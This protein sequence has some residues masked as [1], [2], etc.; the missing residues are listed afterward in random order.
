MD[1]QHY[2]DLIALRS[3]EALEAGEQ[4]ELDEHLRLCAECRR[5]AHESLEAASLI[6]LSAEPIRPPEVVKARLMRE[7]GGRRDARGTTAS[8]WWLAAA[9]MLLAGLLLSQFALWK[10]RRDL[11]S[12]A[13]RVAALMQQKLAAEQKQAELQRRLEVLTNARAIELSGQEVAPS[14]SARVFVDEKQ[15]TA[16]VF[17]RNLPPTPAGKS[18]QLWVIRADQPAPQSAG[19][20]EVGPEGRATLGVENL[21]LNTEIRAF[22]LTVEPRGGVPAPTGAK[23]LVGGV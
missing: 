12:R 4:A 13:D 16:L 8:R 17:F 21:P 5:V 14:A 2:E 22:A 20:F 7:I 23:L 10:T 9:A 19:V 1:H 3:L 11:R 18:Y 6:G 15:R